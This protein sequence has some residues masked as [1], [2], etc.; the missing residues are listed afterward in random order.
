MTQI[1]GTSVPS[2]PPA[3]TGHGNPLREAAV[4]LEATFLFEMLKSAG[5]G[6][7]RSSMGGGPGESQFGSFLAQAQADEI[8]RAGGV[9]LAESLFHALKEAENEK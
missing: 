3:K 5:L 2:L 8:A 1:T 4:K 7:S 9:G 6:Q